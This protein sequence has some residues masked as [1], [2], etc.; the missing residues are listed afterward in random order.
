MTE[1]RKEKRILEILGQVDEQYIEEAAPGQGT[2]K[3][4][5][6]RKCSL[7]KWGAVAAC[8]CA[9]VCSIVLLNRRDT[10]R[11]W[12]ILE[13]TAAPS[14]PGDE[15]FP[16]P[17]WE[18][19]PVYQQYSRVVFAVSA[20]QEPSEYTS[21]GGEVPSERIG[22]ELGEAIAKGWDSYAEIAGEA[23]E[24]QK[25]V[26]VCSITKIS[27]EC[28]IA[29]QYEGTGE[30]YAFTN[31]HYRPQTLGQFVEDLNLREEISFGSV[32][33][34]YRK[35]S[36]EYAT[37]CFDK[38]AQEVIRESLLSETGAGN[39]ADGLPGGS[40]DKIL[41]ISVDIPLL[42]YKNISLSVREEGYIETNILDTGKR[43]FIGTKN[44]QA[45]VDY[46]L[47]ECEGYEL[48]YVDSEGKPENSAEKEPEAEPTST[49]AP[50]RPE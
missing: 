49:P 25:A 31:A 26:K 29:V 40:P 42:G 38:V 5:R 32:Y 27:S 17:R 45:F 21:R 13:V 4:H 39:E 10:V 43:F 50:V 11:T 30:W 41:D 22:E 46:V 44:T 36:G 23:P 20:G 24:R 14:A 12:P 48:V 19:L 15:F 2:E 6:A 9:A 3:L 37:V 35:S 1:L 28:A 18:N 33:Y 34:E 7:L 47:D 16:I 8:A